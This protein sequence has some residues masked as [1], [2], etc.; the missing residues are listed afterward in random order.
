[1]NFRVRGLADGDDVV[2]GTGVHQGALQPLGQHEDGREGKHHKRHAPGG[3]DR[4]HS[5]GQQ[6][7]QTIGKQKF[8]ATLPSASTIRTVITLRIGNAAATSATVTTAS[9]SN[10]SVVGL[11]SMTGKMFPT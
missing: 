10:Q 5:P 2:V 8:H 3:Q 6:V 4:G 11:M 9:T 7:A 1:M